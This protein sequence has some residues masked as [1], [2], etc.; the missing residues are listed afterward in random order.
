MGSLN[1]YSKHDY[2]N[3]VKWQSKSH[4][5]FERI[6]EL[7]HYD[8]YIENKHKSYARQEKQNIT[9]KIIHLIKC[10]TN[11]FDFDIPTS[12]FAILH[13]NKE[14]IEWIINSINYTYWYTLEKNK[15]N[16]WQIW[17]K[18]ELN[19]DVARFLSID[20][21]YS[22]HLETEYDTVFKHATLLNSIRYLKICHTQLHKLKIYS[23]MEQPINI[24]DELYC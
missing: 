20:I 19:A 22:D 14:K 12:K 24:I 5:K 15:K 16:K 7:Y 17:I 8:T 4:D 18:S 10:Y 23:L 21:I 9:D 13:Y 11:S 6:L 1:K 2:I 3:N